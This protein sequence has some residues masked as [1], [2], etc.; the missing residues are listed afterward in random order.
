M[1]V[2]TGAV[3][4]NFRKGKKAM[5]TFLRQRVDE[6]GYTEIS[7]EEALHSLLTTYNDN[8][9]TRDTLNHPGTI[10]YRFGEI[11]VR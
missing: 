1:W 10:P 9:I 2:V 7:K 8:D 4:E 3:P 6:D 11:I 5:L